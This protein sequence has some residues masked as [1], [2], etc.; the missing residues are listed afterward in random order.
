[1]VKAY[2]TMRNFFKMDNM[3]VKGLLSGILSIGTGLVKLVLKPLKRFLILF[4]KYKV[5]VV[6]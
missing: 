3:V 1:M 5:L 4:Y 2:G 6:K